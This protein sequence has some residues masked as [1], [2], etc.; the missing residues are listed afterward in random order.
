[1]AYRKRKDQ[2]L[3]ALRLQY[4]EIRS[5]TYFLFDF[6]KR[7]FWTMSCQLWPYVT[8]SYKH[9]HVSDS[10]EE[11]FVEEIVEFFIKEEVEPAADSKE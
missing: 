10:V 9:F 6:R 2:E 8:A 5:G 1:M 11:E 3:K 7:S 4:E